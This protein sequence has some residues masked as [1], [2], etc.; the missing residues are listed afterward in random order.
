[1]G[2][3]R[4]KRLQREVSE[5]RS[6]D[7]DAR[8]AD[9]AEAAV[10]AQRRKEKPLVEAADRTVDG[11][12]KSSVEGEDTAPKTRLEGYFGSNCRNNVIKP[13]PYSSA[14]K[15]RHPIPPPPEGSEATDAE[16]RRIRREKQADA[17]EPTPLTGEEREVANARRENY[18]VGPKVPVQVRVVEDA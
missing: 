5:I 14:I 8:A 12:Y 2:T 3:R 7:A 9:D 13:T 17:P 18:F 4:K 1:M 15:G 16:K 10:I 11:Y 6:A